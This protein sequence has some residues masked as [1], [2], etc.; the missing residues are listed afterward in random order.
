MREEV[1]RL[2]DTAKAARHVDGVARRIRRI[3]GD[4]GHV[5]GVVGVLLRGRPYCRPVVDAYSAG[6]RQREDAEAG[7]GLVSNRFAQ[8]G[9]G[10]RG[11]EVELELRHGRVRAAP[12]GYLELPDAFGVT[13]V[14]SSKRQLRPIRTG[15]GR[16][17]LLDR[18]GIALAID[19]L[20]V[21]RG[22]G[23]AAIG[24]VTDAVEERD[25]L[26]VGRGIVRS[27][28]DEVRFRL[29]LARMLKVTFKSAMLNELPTVNVVRE[30]VPSPGTV[31]GVASRRRRAAR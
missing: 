23:E 20:I 10:Y 6:G 30:F 26:R 27:D 12:V 16:S 4:G 17:S 14:E 7:A 11:L 21:E 18:A 8:A 31:T 24:A 3:E 29:S 28:E 5:A 15:E 13:V 1:G 22:I 19:R 2:P 9:A 25:P